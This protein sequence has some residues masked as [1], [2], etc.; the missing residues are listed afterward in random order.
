[1][2][3]VTELAYVAGI[4][5]ADGYVTAASSLHKGRRY[6]GPAVGI[7]GNR[8][9][10]HD[11]AAAMFGGNVRIYI[12]RGERAHHQP[13]FQWQLYGARAIVVLEAVLPYLRVKRRQAELCLGLHEA[14]L[15]ARLM[16]GYEDPYPWFG[17]EYDP[18]RDLV[19]AAEEIRGLN[20][21]NAWKR[22]SRELDGRTYD[23]MPA[24]AR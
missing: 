3:E 17:P 12:P 2:H 18:E 1:M 9:E 15:E 6:V 7:A 21:R 5:D 4:I 24:V 11:L 16:K 10:P 14:I 8:R 19:A 22:A 23:E 13:Q 20:T